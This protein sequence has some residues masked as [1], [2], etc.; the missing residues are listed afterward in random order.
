MIDFIE[1]KIDSLTENHVTFDVNGV[2][3]GIHIS[4]STYF[5]LKDKTGQVRVYTYLNVREDALE[6]YGFTSQEEKE[7]FLTLISVNGIGAKAGTA[8]L[9][10]ITIDRL[11]KAIGGGDTAT[12]TKIPG[13]GK[14]KAER[15]IV[16][17]KD[18]FKDMA[19]LGGPAVAIPEEEEYI[20]ILSAL[21][22]NY[23]QAREA[24]SA[25]IR[26][27][28]AKADKETVI[29]QALKRLGR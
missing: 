9:G 7:T 6:L 17:L 21:G 10:N 11:K 2:G 5:H 23:N 28:G 1:G 24:L 22:F 14:K 19:A 27:T 26:E 15:I 25:A 29:K 16:E 13:L 20:E 3:Y 12:L 4:Q 18:K 8:I